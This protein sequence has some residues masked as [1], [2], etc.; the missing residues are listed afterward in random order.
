MS[1]PAI[2]L[3]TIVLMARQ[4]AWADESGKCGANV[5]YT[6]EESTYTLTVCGS[7]AMDDY[8]DYYSWSIYERPWDAIGF[9]D[10]ILKIVIESGV[11]HIGKYAFAECLSLEEVVFKENSQLTTIGDSAF[12]GCSSLPEIIIPASV[13]R[14][15]SHA[16]GNTINLETVTFAKNSQLTSIEDFAFENTSLTGF[17]IPAGVTNIGGGVFANCTDLQFLTVAQGNNVFQ[18]VDGVLFNNDL[19]TLIAYPP[20]NPQNS[21]TI[22]AC[23][24]R[25]ETAAFLG[26]RHLE[27]I[28]YGENTH[29]TTIGDYAFFDCC[30]LLGITIP[31]SVTSI[32]YGAFWH[33][34]LITVTFVDI[35]KLNY[36]G[37]N[38]FE[39][40]PWFDF[41][42]W[43]DALYL[44]NVLYRV[45]PSYDGVFDIDDGVVCIAGGAFEGCEDLTG[46]TIPSSVSTIGAYA[47]NE[48]ISLTGI[49]TIPDNVTVIGES[50]FQN[51]IK[52]EGIIIPASVTSIGSSAFDYCLGLSSVTFAENSQLTSIGKSAFKY[53]ESLTG[54]NIP[55]NVTS[56]GS[57]AFYGSGIENITFAD[58]SSISTID[59]FTFGEC[60]LADISIPAG[61]TV[62]GNGAFSG[63]FNL[64]EVTFSE[65]SALAIIGKGAFEN[66]SLLET[67]SFAENTPLT[68]IRDNAFAQCEKLESVT[69]DRVP[70]LEIIGD[71]AFYE[72]FD[73]A[74]LI[75]PTCVTSIGDNAF[76]ECLS[77]G[78]IYVLPVLPPELG[79]SAFS[80]LDP[81]ICHFYFHDSIY[82]S[83]NKRIW[84]NHGLDDAPY[85]YEYMGTVITPDGITAVTAS[86]PLITLYGKD[87]YK[88]DIE[89]TLSGSEDIAPEGYVSPLLGYGLNRTL[90]AGSTFVMPVGD[91]RVCTLWTPISWDGS[92]TQ[93]DPYLIQYPSQ[94]DLLAKNVNNG[95]EY[96]DTYFK[97]KNDITYSY[98]GLGATESNYTAIGIYDDKGTD[99]DTDD[100]DF[101][102]RGSFDGN[103]KTISGIRIYNAGDGGTQ[104]VFGQ[105]AEEGIVKNLTLADSRITGLYLL[106]GIAGYCR[107]IIDNCHI[108]ESVIISINVWRRAE[109]IG[110]I[111][112]YNGNDII[113]C[114]S[115]AIITFADNAENNNFIGGIAG[116]NENNIINCTSS[117]KISFGDNAMYNEYIGGIVG[118]S[119]G[120]GIISNCNSSAIISIGNNAFNNNVIGGIAGE[121]YYSKYD[122]TKAVIENC[123]SS[124]IISL[125][126][127]SSECNFIGGIVGE[128]WNGSLINNIAVGVSI[129]GSE[130]LGAIGGHEDDINTYKNNYYSFC[131]VGDATTGIG[132]SEGDISADDGAVQATILIETES[133]PTTIANGDKVVFRR[134]FK[135]GVSSTVCLPVAIDAAKATAAGKFFTFAG[136]DMTDPDDWAVVMQE[137]AGNNLVDG[138][139]QTNTPYLFIPDADG[140]VLFIGVADGTSVAA[141][142]ATNGDWSFA[143]TYDSIEWKAGHA[144][145]G[146]VYGFA[147]QTY[148]APDNDGDSNPDYTINPGKFVMAA[149]GASIAPYRAYLTY[150][151]AQ[152]AMTR[153]ASNNLSA[154]PASMKVQ[155]LGTDGNTTAVGQIDTATGNVTIDAWYDLNGRQIEGVPAQGGMYI[156][157]GKTIMINE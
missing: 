155:L 35:S 84:I 31:S 17:T 44:G 29:L 107:G 16:F 83:V 81:S 87:Y 97:L 106:G 75:I 19:T 138:D 116:C 112:G 67:V 109:S 7:G 46:V 23:V 157:N 8:D 1:L 120:G 26:C 2:M 86:Q 142:N 32:G 110:G 42:S 51:C 137:V 144:D 50:T 36:I 113:N 9:I 94:L 28:A 65:S 12:Y 118:E 20:G 129:I 72:C 147:A 33:S 90:L 95:E 141:G 111:V 34:D 76:R 53:C 149:A 104:G 47:F 5:Y 63:C 92:G 61:V 146:R 130:Y 101:Y 59:N 150:N 62:I 43:S 40:T 39:D 70:Q 4:T 64:Q 38:A 24:T 93:D 148:E 22:P 57:S 89:F 123:K 121:N 56:I 136:V 78:N 54:I 102:F 15:G 145:L 48:C 151:P 14:I 125:G 37:R 156:H 82:N 80:G 6:Y 128:N 85:H 124:A 96:I 132:T 131:A 49:I 68:T 153:G 66:C 91:A 18:V 52:L 88:P 105:I 30:N 77:L 27:T 69:F 119:S 115:S 79:S 114:T 58:N 133:A 3:F 127:N 134:E 73:L 45:D 117:A 21:Y 140:P 55:A 139:L 98:E 71:N 11:T 25:I 122:E 108:L 135:R 103:G 126:F 60:A 10:D 41:L 99:T 100:D 154:L 143:G 74:S 152:H 13:T